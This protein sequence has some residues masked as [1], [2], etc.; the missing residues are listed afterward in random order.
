ML[1]NCWA[2]RSALLLLKPHEVLVEPH[3]AEEPLLATNARL[4]LTQVA[5]MF[6]SSLNAVG[7]R[8]RSYPLASTS[9]LFRAKGLPGKFDD[10]GI[11]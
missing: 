11:W 2:E 9:N 4:E 10:G 5:E 1:A 3:T 7:G 6:D 8:H